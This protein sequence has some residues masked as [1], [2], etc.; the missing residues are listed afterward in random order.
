MVEDRFGYF[1]VGVTEITVVG[2][3]IGVVLNKQ[4]MKTTPFEKGSRVDVFAQLD[5]KPRFLAGRNRSI[6][7][8]GKYSLA[9]TFDHTNANLKGKQ[10]TIYLREHKSE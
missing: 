8:I 4:L 9:V 1:T 3:S 7:V 10:L 6:Q 5:G 2:N